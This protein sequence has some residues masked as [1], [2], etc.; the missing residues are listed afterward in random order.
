MEYLQITKKLIK[1]WNDNNIIYCHWK[2]NE[3]LY[4]G[5]SG[6]TDLDMLVA[7][8]CKD[9]CHSLLNLCGYK[10]AFSQIGAKYPNVEDWIGFDEETG[11][12]VHIHL[13]FNI[14]T[15]KKFV[16]EFI[17]PWDVEMFS[18]LLKDTG[19][20]VYVP[21]P[22]LELI[23]LKC[24][25]ILK[26]SYMK[27]LA[28]RLGKKIQ[29]SQSLQ[30]ELNYLYQKA[31]KDEIK[32]LSS[33]LFGDDSEYLLDYFLSNENNYNDSFK[34]YGRLNKSLSKYKRFSTFKTLF[35]HIVNRLLLDMRSYLNNKGVTNYINKKTLNTKGCLIAFV[36]ADG[37]GKSTV[38]S[39]TEKWLKWKLESKRFYLGS[40]D[41]Y[42]PLS[43]RII[44]YLSS[45][46]N[47][48]DKHTAGT[49]TKTEKKNN[50]V[51]RKV[52][53]IRTMAHVY[54]SFYQLSVV[55]H[56]YKTLCKAD[57]YRSKGGIALLDRYPQQ[58][59]EGINDGPKIKARYGL[60]HNNMLFRWLSNREYK[61]FENIAHINPDLVI[62]LYVSPEESVRRKPDH[63]IEEVSQKAA[64]IAALNFEH[65]QLY[66]VNTEQDFQTEIVEIR[67][68]VWKN[69]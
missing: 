37:C 58:Q 22:S 69:L 39:N 43:K 42:N 60:I 33:V 59:F 4:E 57:E 64:V 53:F 15:G 45:L 31:N 67:N 56:T 66:S 65:S 13:H 38:T 10:K 52:G 44:T 11:K 17:L 25:I 46:K 1:V 68:L 23:I 20:D 6:D 8:E 30:K 18:T 26:C 40:G 61:L 14:I 12:L 32:K 19:T 41:H 47:K 29:Y 21:A 50:Q 34:Y 9:K 5:L 54:D 16:K 27:S 36:G 2:S 35:M 51:N 24:R 7:K 63:D 62:K 3:H 49:K 48:N 55:K 28:L